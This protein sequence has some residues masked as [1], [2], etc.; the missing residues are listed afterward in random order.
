MH[1]SCENGAVTPQSIQDWLTM[2]S[3]EMILEIIHSVSKC[4]FNIHYMPNIV[5]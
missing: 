3:G 1:P 2:P 5:T 4:L